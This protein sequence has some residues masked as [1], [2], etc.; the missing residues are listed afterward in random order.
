[1]PRMMLSTE[2]A[3]RPAAAVAGRRAVA[4]TWLEASGGDATRTSR[5]PERM[6]RLDMK[7]A[8]ENEHL[9]GT[10]HARAAWRPDGAG[11]IL[12][13]RTAFPLVSSI[14]VVC[15][16]RTSPARHRA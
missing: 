12:C 11:S 1:G 9:S 16:P 2:S 7:A 6:K 13:R 15:H 4:A 3:T 8:G 14:A 10:G 5:R